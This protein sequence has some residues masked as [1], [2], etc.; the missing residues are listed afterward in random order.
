[1]LLTVQDC[2]ATFSQ[3]ECLDPALYPTPEGQ[4]YALSALYWEFG[5]TLGFDENPG[6][7]TVST[8]VDQKCQEP[9]ECEICSD[10]DC[11][12]VRYYTTKRSQSKGRF[13]APR[14]LGSTCYVS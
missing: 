10:T 13:R 12:E 1:M 14:T 9:V 4:F 7:D 8:L 5:L 11:F 6:M 3:G 2:N